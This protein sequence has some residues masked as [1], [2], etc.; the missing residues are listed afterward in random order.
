MAASN[1]VIY[2]DRFN[3]GLNLSRQA[4]YLSPSETP[5]CLNVDFD[6]RGGFM[7]RSGFVGQNDDALLAGGLFLGPTY[8]GGD[9]VLIQGDG[10]ELLEWDGT[11]VSNTAATLTDALTTKV[12]MA[13]F[14]DKAYF[15]NGRAAGVIVMKAWNG[16]TLSTLGSTFNDDLLAPN[17][18]DMPDAQLICSHK[19][20]MF[21]ADTNESGTRFPNRV[22]YSHLG[23]PE[24]WHT[25]HY[26]D[27]GDPDDGDPIVALV[28]F[29]DHLLIFRHT[30]IHAIYGY[31][32]DSWVRD[33]LAVSSGVRDQ[34]CVTANM[35]MVFWFSTEG[36]VVTY[37]G[38]QLRVISEPIEHWTRIGN[39]DSTV[40]GDVMWGHDKLFLVVGAGPQIVASHLLFVWDMF[41]KTWTRYSPNVHSM[42]FWREVDSADLQLFMFHDDDDIYVLDETSDFDVVGGVTVPFQA[43]YRTAWLT[44][45]ETATKKRWKRPRISAAA[46]ASTTI[47]VD[48]FHNFNEQSRTRTS[49]V[50]IVAGESG[51][52]W[53]ENWGTLL[54]GTG[55]VETY[56]FEHSPA[57]GSSYAVQF[58]FANTAATRWWV[59]SVAVPFRRKQVK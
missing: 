29:A 12:R 51:G 17:A 24:D 46:N 14:G 4:Q 43:Y 41:T 44:A 1:E 15:A 37:D 23:F 21:I 52:L 57:A 32:H 18:G 11:A 33:Q 10:G 8:F 47:R 13:T 58:L 49:D 3:G 38:N 34:S 59:D 42:M 56:V 20:H 26:I 35:N 16:S 45:G 39:I 54:W 25:D 55:D 2:L 22:R 36:N 30:Q 5:D 28:S 53:G 48:V 19:N 7:T 40:H 9:V 50:A 6:I 27:I 31:D